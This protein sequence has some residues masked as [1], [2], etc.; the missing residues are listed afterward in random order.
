MVA[1]VHSYFKASTGSGSILMTSLTDTTLT[2]P[3]WPG[4]MAVIRANG[5]SAAPIPSSLTITNW[6]T[7]K[8]L[9]GVFHVGRVINRG[10]YS[11]LYLALIFWY[12]WV[13]K[14]HRLS[15][16][17]FVNVKSDS[18]QGTNCW[19]VIK[20][21]GVNAFKSSTSSDSGHNG[22]EFRHRSTSDKTVETS[23][24]VNDISPKD[25]RKWDFRD[26]TPVSNSPPKWG[27]WG[28]LKDHSIFNFPRLLFNPLSILNAPEICGLGLCGGVLRATPSKSQDYL[29]STSFKG[30]TLQK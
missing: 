12:T 27:F 26:F 8:S 19:P 1:L 4:W 14:C 17:D 10:R 30:S 22:L 20:W 11:R 15:A 29:Q 3:S 16:P 2:M 23:S 7:F 6:P 21:L 18:S 25:V 9:A 24:K 28:G 13:I 5:Q